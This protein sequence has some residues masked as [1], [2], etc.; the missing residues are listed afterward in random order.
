MRWATRQ[1]P[2]ARPTEVPPASRTARRRERS[3]RTV[4]HTSHAP[5]RRGLRARRATT[6]PRLRTGPR[7]TRATAAIPGRRAGT[8][9]P[10]TLPVTTSTEGLQSP[11]GERV[12]GGRP[13]SRRQRASRRPDRRARQRDSR[14][15]RNE[16]AAD[17]AASVSAVVDH[18]DA[19]SNEQAVHAEA[20][21]AQ[22]DVANVAVNVRVGSGGDD[23]AVSQTNAATG[24]ASAGTTSDAPSQASPRH[25]PPRRR[26]TRQIPPSPSVSS[27]RETTG[28]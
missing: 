2:R 4:L 15:Q 14:H 28:R 10:T 7:T 12:L 13:A 3:R 9:T 21:A 18:P 23:G 6:T 24:S 26:S 11:F 16:A 22:S 5:R 8:G 17:A 25:G 27:R 1:G 19:A 20:S